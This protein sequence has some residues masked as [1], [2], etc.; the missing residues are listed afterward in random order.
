MKC[1]ETE[2]KVTKTVSSV[3]CPVVSGQKLSHKSDREGHGFS[4]A[5]KGQQRRGL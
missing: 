4:R 2:T 5:A 1:G 3:Q